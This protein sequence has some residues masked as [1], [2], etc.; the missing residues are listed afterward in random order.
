MIKYYVF[1]RWILA[2][3]IFISYP[4]ILENTSIN[5]LPTVNLLQI[6]KG[7]K[8]IQHNISNR[9]CYPAS[10]WKGSVPGRDEQKILGMFSKSIYSEEYWKKLK[11]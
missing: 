7:G 6:T 9:Y 3:C 5:P 4:N 10:S 11:N 2:T 1:L 8:H